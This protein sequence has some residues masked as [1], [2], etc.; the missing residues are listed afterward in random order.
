MHVHK[1]AAYFAALQRAVRARFLHA[2]SRSAS[3]ANAWTSHLPLAALTAAFTN[4]STF[5]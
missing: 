4:A 2:R 1:F 3:A 5:A